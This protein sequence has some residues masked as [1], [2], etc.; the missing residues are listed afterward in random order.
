[1]NPESGPGPESIYNLEEENRHIVLSDKEKEAVNNITLDI[2]EVDEAIRELAT[3]DVIKTLENGHPLNRVVRDRDENITGYIACE[4][5]IPHEAYIKYF[6]T[7]GQLG[8]SLFREIPAFLEYAEKQ[9][10]IKINFHGWNPK[11]NHALERFGFKRLKTDSMNEFSV[12]FYEKSL[13]EQKTPEEVGR[14]RANAFEQK[15]LNKINKEYEQTLAKLP[16]ESRQEKESKISSIFDS[17]VRRLENTEGFDLGERERAVLRLKLARH[18]QTNDTI[19]ENVLYDAFIETPK[20]LSSD[21]GSF[22]RLLEI[23]QEKTVQKIAEMRKKRAEI[24]GDSEYNPYEN[25]FETTSGNYYMARLLNM[26][27]LE[28][29]SDYMGHCVGTSDSYVNR[30]KNGDI[31]ILSFRHK[32]PYDEATGKFE[33]RPIITI[34]YNLRTNAIEQVKKANDEYLKPSD[35]YFS[36]VIDALKQLR[37]SKTDLGKRRDFKKIASSEL[38]NIP[39]ADY[40]LLTDKGEISFRDFDPESNAFVLKIGNMEI[41]SSMPKNDAKKIL[42]IVED[43]DALENAIAIGQSELTKDT[44]VYIGPIFKE[45]WHTYP[46][47]EHIYTS[48]PE[49]KIS[50]SELMMGGLD[51][52]QLQS[53][54]NE[55]CKRPNGEINIS[56]F[57]QNKLNDI[58][59]SPEFAHL[60]QNP[61]KINLVRLKVRDLGFPDGATTQE[62]YDKA[63]ELGLELCPDEVGPYQRINDTEQTLNNWY[64][65]AMKQFTDR[66]GHPDVFSFGR[67]GDGLWLRDAWAGPGGR[68]SAGRGF[69]F[70]LRKVS[71]ES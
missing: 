60:I 34:E 48:F 62:I 31:E 64:S 56:E 52:D 38:E 9:G 21:K 29:E 66:H 4:D 11:L 57:A 15:Y 1:M 42:K 22:F 33:D 17:L 55:V 35:P 46:K 51:K 10:Y 16:K 67:S 45:L 19:D 41:T 14:E 40:C 23:H 12:D 63:E 13:K 28:Q 6:G 20:F 50:Q 70:R 24:S 2:E 44:T 8:R 59:A 49:G 18:F 61:E 65:I 71:Q 25:L 36:D 7:K 39:V 68:W 47:L 5:F 3:E 54:L 53:K 43:I 32:A 27:H 69:V 58:Y 37:E 26:P 30:I